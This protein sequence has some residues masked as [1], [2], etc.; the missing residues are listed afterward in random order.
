[1]NKYTGEKSWCTRQC[2]IAREK[3]TEKDPRG[4]KSQTKLDNIFN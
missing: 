1:M 4:E 3:T 2:E